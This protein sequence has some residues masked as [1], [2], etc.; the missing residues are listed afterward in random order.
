M[1]HLQ[2]SRELRLFFVHYPDRNSF[3]PRALGMTHSLSERE[4]HLFPRRYFSE[5]GQKVIIGLS[6]AETSEFE[7]LEDRAPLHADG[8][9]A[10]DFEGG[11]QSADERK[12]LLLY[13]KHDRAYNKVKLDRSLLRRNSELHG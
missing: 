11:P 12:W 10:W 3:Q 7:L 4:R 13:K 5:N 6:P 9:I 2:P 1:V 8:T